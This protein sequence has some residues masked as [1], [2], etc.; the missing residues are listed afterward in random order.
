MTCAKRTVT[1]EIY[2]DSPFPV[3]T[4]SN[5]CENPQPVCPRA[6]GEDYTKCKTICR[7]GGHAEIAAIEFAKQR[8]ID[9]RGGTAIVKGHYWICEPC[10]AALRDA[11]V[12]RV[13]IEQ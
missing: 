4:A 11:G 3:I 8:G 13:V 10:G 5:A 2:V 12:I 9:I 7:Q 6:P 1:C